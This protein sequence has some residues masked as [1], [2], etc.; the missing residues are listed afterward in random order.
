MFAI[1]DH[2]RWFFVVFLFC[3]A[4]VLANVVHYVL[5]RLL[6][7]DEAAGKQLGWGLQKHLGAPAR[8]VFLL[9]CVELVLPLAPG[10]PK[11]VEAAARHGVFMVIVV[12]MGWFCIGLVYVAQ[13]FLLRKYDIT[14]ADNRRARSIHTQFQLFRRVIIV[15]VV[16]LTLG[17]LLWTSNDTRLLHYGSGLLA[18]AGLAS[19]LLASAAKTTVS[20]FLAG[21][22]IA[23][24]EPIR[25]DDVVVVAG[26][27]ARVEEITSAYVVLKIWDLRRLIVPLSWFIE[28]P[29]AN[30]T[31]TSA[32]ILTYSYLYL[33]YMV[34]V[35]EVRAQLEKVV[36]AA[37]QWDGTVVGCQVTNLTAQSME[38]RCLMGSPDSGKAFDLQC[39]VREEMMEWVKANYPEAYPNMR[40]R[41]VGEAPQ[42]PATQA[43]NGSALDRPTDSVGGLDE[44]VG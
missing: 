35:K 39:L 25:I 19:L 32:N 43:I 40:Y 23:L 10:M 15:F 24:T 13:D 33:D 2:H 17:A 27:W 8:V 6:K 12:S 41:A 16:V 5:F 4:L 20:N 26:E 38:I 34:P 42:V 11:D 31:R 22:Q 9:T 21:L 28:N 37:P 44:A 1:Y 29:F 18:S 36:K 3:G 14:A 30:W 7:K